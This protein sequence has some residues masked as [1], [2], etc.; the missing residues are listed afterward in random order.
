MVRS[1]PNS[2]RAAAIG[3]AILAAS[4]SAALARPD[5]R[6]MTCAQAQQLVKRSG[7]IVLSTGQ[8]T[9]SR[10]VADRR[11]CGH[12][13]ILRPNYAPTRDTAQCPV[14]YFCERVVR[15]RN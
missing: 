2:L 7:A 10:F 4:A 9:Y 13:E 3:L 15:P 1:S 12:Y 11:Y 6:T 5:T 8:Y 14:A